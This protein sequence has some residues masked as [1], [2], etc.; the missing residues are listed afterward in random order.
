MD[1]NQLIFREALAKDLA[2]IIKFLSQDEVSG[3]RENSSA[4][5][6]QEYLNAFKRIEDDKNNEL[7]VAEI[8][9]KVVGTLQIAY[10]PYLTGQ[11]EI[12][13]QIEAMQIDPGLRGAGVGTKLMSWAIERAKEKG[14]GMVQLNC[15][16]L[17]ERSH[18]F[19]KKLGFTPTH[20]GFKLN[21]GKPYSGE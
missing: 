16:K 15:H 6:T 18:N 13:A 21:F 11:G 4:E 17:R 3:S 9:S 20:L 1:F 14:C 10:I 7:I 12:R 8:D 5:V 2:T 19:Y